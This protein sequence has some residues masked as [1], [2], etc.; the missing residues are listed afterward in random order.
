MQNIKDAD[1]EQKK[2]IE[3]ETASTNKLRQLVAIYDEV[4]D[5]SGPLQIPNTSSHATFCK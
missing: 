1:K 3:K 5:Y 2:E 4:V